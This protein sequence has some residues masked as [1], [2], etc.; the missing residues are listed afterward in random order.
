M[1][2]QGKFLGN[3]YHVVGLCYAKQNLRLMYIY[4]CCLFTDGSTVKAML[5]SFKISP[6]F[7]D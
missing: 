3:L 7:I 5:L 4:E 2:V 1:I 6:C